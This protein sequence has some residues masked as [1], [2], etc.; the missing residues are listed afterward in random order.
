[1]NVLSR[2][3]FFLNTCSFAF[4][5]ACGSQKDPINFDKIDY[6]VKNSLELL[7]ETSSNA[8]ELYK[9]AAGVL[10]FPLISEV[11][12][13]Y[14]G[15]F[16]RGSLQIKDE[17][18]GYYSALA[19]S[20]GVQLGIK[21]YSHCIFFMTEDSLAD[22]RNSFGYNIGADFSFA[23]SSEASSVG[24]DLRGSTAPVIGVIFD[25]EGLATGISL[26]GVKYSQI[27]P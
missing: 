10:V 15:S 9:N 24:I 16:G 3:V 19:A 17:T 12:F 5:G 1:M 27:I 8:A 26:E 14:G 22:F 18:V 21:Q 20:W 4:L 2:R 6:Q 11:S 25:Q 7:L 23:F 13:G